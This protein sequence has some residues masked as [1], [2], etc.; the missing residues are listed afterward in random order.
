MTTSTI[1]LLILSVFI[2]TGLSYYQ[3][4]Y[5]AKSKSKIHLLLAFLRFLSYVG[6][7]LLLINP[8]ISN[9]SYEIVKTPLPIIVDNSKSIKELSGNH[10]DSSSIKQLTENKTLNEKYNLQLYTFDKEFIHNGKIDYLGKQSLLD[11]VAKNLKQLYRNIN[12]PVVLFTDGNQTQGSD[13]VYSFQNN[14]KIYP[15]VQGDTTTVFDLKINQINVNKY[16][17]LKNKFPV[18]VFVQYNGNQNVTANFAITTGNQTVF[19]KNITFTSKIKAQ[20]IS[21]LLDANAIGIQKYTATITSAETEK[22]KSNNT[23]NFVVEVIDQRTEIALVSDMVHPDLSALKRSIE[24]NEQ[25]KVSLLKPNEITD[26]KK[27]NLFIFYQPNATFKALFEANKNAE[28]NSLLI[29]G[30]QTDFNFLNAYQT[31]FNFKMGNQ[32]EDYFASF[33]TDFT[34][35]AQENIGF[36]NFSS[37]ENKFGT[38]TVKGNAKTLLNASIRN[39]QTENPLFT[40]FEEG[41]NRRG[42]LFG[43]N[44]WKWR[45]ET[46]LKKKSFQDFDFFTDKWVQFLTSNTTKKSLEVDFKKYYNEGET[47]EITA[48]YFDKNY[49]LDQNAQLNIVVT[50]KETKFKKTYNFL[51]SNIDYKVEFDNLP[52]G[53]YSFTVTENSSKA[54]F[55]GSFEIL[56]FDIE[57]QFVNPDRI[58]L[59]QLAATTSG[60]LFYPNQ[61]DQL[62]KILSDSNSYLPVQKE[63]ITKKPLIDWKLLLLLIVSFLSLEWFIRKYNGLL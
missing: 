61:L 45:M 54:S 5:K 48:Q 47:I 29:T 27:Y 41:K 43:E 4:F 13:Y 59:E 56:E 46:N 17:F 57:R 60:K 63:V 7:F 16:T 26:L 50:N 39:I 55:S 40:F 31:D 25:R 10:L 2:A 33:N 8:I 19:K 15:V 3:Y 18:E 20:S 53:N 35:F 51:K 34:V 38:I 49:E 44:I 9:A 23:Q 6:L 36:E 21:V 62:I 37:L 32:K 28:I 22:N 14:T 42:Y 11:N 12:Y 58:R 1:L 30:T 24:V 52:K